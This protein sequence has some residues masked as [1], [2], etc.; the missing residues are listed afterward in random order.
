MKKIV[1]VIVSLV[2][3][4]GITISALCLPAKKFE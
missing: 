1:M 3:I 2:A 4:A